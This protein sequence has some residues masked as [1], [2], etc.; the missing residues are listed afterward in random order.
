[1][2]LCLL[3]KSTAMQ[4]ECFM[5]ECSKDS[6]HVFPYTVRTSDEPLQPGDTTVIEVKCPFCQTWSQVDVGKKVMPDKVI[7]RGGKTT[8]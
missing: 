4:E 1:M 8:Q 3:Q 7:I 2:S 6:E 5:I